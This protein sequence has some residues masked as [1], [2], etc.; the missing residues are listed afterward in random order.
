ML[1][2]GKVCAFPFRCLPMDMSAK[3][4]LWS[5][6][7]FAMQFTYLSVV[8]DELYI[9]T[10]SVVFHN[11]SVPRGRLHASKP[12]KVSMENVQDAL[13]KPGGWLGMQPKDLVTYAGEVHF[14]WENQGGL[15]NS[16]V[17]VWLSVEEAQLYHLGTSCDFDCYTELAKSEQP[18]KDRTKRS[19]RDTLR[20]VATGGIQPLSKFFPHSLVKQVMPPTNIA[21]MVPGG[22]EPLTYEDLLDT[23]SN[24]ATLVNSIKARNFKPHEIDIIMQAFEEAA[25]KEAL[26]DSN[27]NQ[28]VSINTWT[29]HFQTSHTSEELTS[30]DDSAFEQCGIFPCQICLQ[31][32]TSDSDR[33]DHITLAHDHSRTRTNM[34]IIKSSFPCTPPDALDNWLALLEYFAVTPAYPPPF[35]ETLYHELKDKPLFNHILQTFARLILAATTSQTEGKTA[36]T[37]HDHSPVPLHRLIL[38][39]QILILALLEEDRLNTIIQCVQSWLDKFCA[40]DIIGLLEEATLLTSCSPSEIQARA[41]H[42]D[43]PRDKA[44]QELADGGNISGLAQLIL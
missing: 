2:T 9:M 32:F 39:F 11:K 38:L 25:E 42:S 14:V 8:P 41:M 16:L 33:A 21:D 28:D 26:I 40:G 12:T 30:T 4:V 35:R 1:L 19:I 31:C 29:K 44:V 10:K 20:A 5:K 3:V 22:N 27:N 43:T 13:R 34:E 23:Y 37:A 17:G 15:Y 6:N 24:V 18:N 7:C 36:E